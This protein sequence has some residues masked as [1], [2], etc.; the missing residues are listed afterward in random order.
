MIAKDLV[1]QGNAS[2]V[3]TLKIDGEY[4]PTKEYVD[5]A[6]S[7][8]TAYFRGTFATKAELNSYTGAKTNNDYA[9]VSAD[10][11]N[12]N[13]TWRYKYNGTEWTAEYR[14]NESAL[15]VTQL[16]ALNSGITST[17]LKDLQTKTSLINNGNIVFPT[18]GVGIVSGQIKFSGST[19]GANIYYYAPASDEGHLVFNMI[20]DNNTR[21]DFKRSGGSTT[22]A[23]VSYITM[24]DGVYHGNAT[25]L[26]GSGFRTINDTISRNGTKLRETLLIYGPTIGNNTSDL[27]NPGRLTYGD[28]VPQIVFN[29]ANSLTEGQ[30]LGL[31]Y[32][33]HDGVNTG[34][35]LAL[36][37]NSAGSP[38]NFVSDVL[39]A[40]QRMSIP[41]S[42][43][44][45]P[46]N[47]DIWIE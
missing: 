15:T 28:A 43:P 10:E 32:T 25:G 21:I 14:V 18:V 31:L 11:S 24:S 5:D 40:R 33:D 19:D 30:P 41:T 17:I 38:S 6:I 34:S 47:G 42:A 2:I 36:V 9:V 29:T 35:T 3:G 44:S 45:N 8:N 7:T 13:E 1:V 27:Q 16:N 22:E 12:N 39:I 20:D 4:V 46:K 37:S 23:T 26:N